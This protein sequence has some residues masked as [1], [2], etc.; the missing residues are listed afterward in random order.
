MSANIQ[1]QNPNIK[2]LFNFL[3]NNNCNYNYNNYYLPRAVMLFDRSFTL[4][5]KFIKEGDV[6]VKMTETQLC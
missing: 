6:F 1:N 3:Y 2:P 5:K 4:L